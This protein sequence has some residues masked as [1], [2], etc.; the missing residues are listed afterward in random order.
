MLEIRASRRLCSTV[1]M[2]GGIGGRSRTITRHQREVLQVDRRWLMTWMASF[3]SSLVFVFGLYAIYKATGPH[4][5]VTAFIR[6]LKHEVRW[7]IPGLKHKPN[8]RDE[9]ARLETD[10]RRRG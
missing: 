6:G 8:A 5:E 2:A 4:P 9:G 1:S 10:V 3:V 7:L